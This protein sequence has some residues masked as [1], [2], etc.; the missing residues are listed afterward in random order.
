LDEIERMERRNPE[1]IKT[2]FNLKTS[3]TGQ[4]ELR[5]FKKENDE[6]FDVDG[7]RIGWRW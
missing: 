2:N 1:K 7:F 5:E 4:D 3:K 6:T